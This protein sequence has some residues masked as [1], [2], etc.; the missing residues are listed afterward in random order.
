MLLLPYGAERYRYQPSA[1]LFTAIGYYKPVLQSPEMNPEILS[2]FSV[3]EA[4][5]LDS[6]DIFSHQLETFVNSFSAHQKEYR[7]GLIGANRKYGQDKL[8]QRIIE[9]LSA[10]NDG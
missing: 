4:V 2:E 3:G 1:M 5:Q 9:V 10:E 8:I 7:D 6:V